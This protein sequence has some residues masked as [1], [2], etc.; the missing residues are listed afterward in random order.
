MLIDMVYV[1]TASIHRHDIVSKTTYLKATAENFE[2]LFIFLMFLLL[3][4]GLDLNL[5]ETYTFRKTDNKLSVCL[6]D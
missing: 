3:F 2:S 5:T 1:V 6:V 4:V